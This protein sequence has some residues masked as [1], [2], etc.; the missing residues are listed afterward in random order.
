[1]QEEEDHPARF[2]LSFD[3]FP[4]MAIFNERVFF[5]GAGGCIGVGS[6]GTVPAW[7]VII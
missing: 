3:S 2:R 4:D 7:F 1:M 5:C 6:H